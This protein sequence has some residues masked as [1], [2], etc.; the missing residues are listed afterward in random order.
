METK[1]YAE[2][3]KK[4]TTSKARRNRGYLARFGMES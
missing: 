3:K 1:Y 2:K 4:K